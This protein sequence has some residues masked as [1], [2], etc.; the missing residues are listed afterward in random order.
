MPR[1]ENGKHEKSTKKRRFRWDRVVDTSHR[2]LPFA[3]G[4]SYSRYYPNPVYPPPEKS[5]GQGEGVHEQ[6]AERKCLVRLEVIVEAIFSSA[7]V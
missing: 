4:L 3:C 7:S 5:F 1:L 2:A 6:G